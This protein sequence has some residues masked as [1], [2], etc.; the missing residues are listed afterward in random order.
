MNLII[1]IGNTKT[2]LGVFEE[3]VLIK[4]LTWEQWDLPKLQKL[5]RQWKI[6]S[7][8]LSVVGATKIEVEQYLAE[9]FDFLKLSAKTSLPIQNL[10]GTPKTLGKDRLAAVMGAYQLFPA[11]TC[12]VIDAGTCITY[13]L[14]TKTGDYLGGNITPG[15]KMRLQAM[16]HFTARLP[17]VRQQ[18]TE[19]ILGTTSVTAIRTGAQ[20]GA[21]FEMEGFIKAYRKEFGR[22]KVI[23]T[24]GAAD[25]F[26][27]HLKT[28]IFVEPNLVF[29][30]LNKILNHN[31][32]S[33]E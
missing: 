22:L 7:I 28:K 23:L 26:A 17:L 15:V 14:L 5:L 30:G 31:V 21:V 3:G 9:N 32:Q 8:A 27:N 24:G 19:K 33:L 18:K 16:Q 25:F 4:K 29:L 1:D 6:Q 20:F 10:Y 12:L 11:H 13:D 2:K